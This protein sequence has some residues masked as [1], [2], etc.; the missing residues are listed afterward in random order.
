MKSN[1]PIQARFLPGLISYSQAMELME[2]LR[3]ERTKGEIPDQILFLEHP[4]II[5]MG[6]RPAQQDLK[7]SIVELQKKGIDFIETDRGGKLTYHGPGQLVIYFIFDLNQRALS[8][9]DFVWKAEEG[10]KLYLKTLDI[11]VERDPQNPG[12]WIG[13]QKIASVG[14]HIQKGITTHGVA[15]NLTCDLTPFSY[16]VPCGIP[17]TIPTSV[18]LQTGKHV[19]VLEAGQTLQ[20]CYVQIFK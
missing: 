1:F 4:P 17:S 10:L 3:V 7:L 18:L 15:L 6:R 19:S 16:M 14:F 13:L 8:I 2:K 12:L 9:A 11:L 20:T 5:T